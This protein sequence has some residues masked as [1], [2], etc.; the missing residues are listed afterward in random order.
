MTT[1]LQSQHERWKEARA[2]L[3]APET[4]KTPPR[5]S[6]GGNI[7]VLVPPTVD[8]EK[9]VMDFIVAAVGNVAGLPVNEIISGPPLKEVTQ[10]RNL[11][12]ALCVKRAQFQIDSISRHFEVEPAC[13]QDSA[14]KLG[15]ILAKH[16]ISHKTPLELSLPTIWASW[17]ELVEVKKYPSIRGIQKAVCHV[18]QVTLTDL[19][20]A[21][22]PK[23]IVEPRQIGMALC[24]RLTLKSLPE[25]GRLFGGR[26]H[27][28]VLHAGRKYH[29]LLEKVGSTLPE[30]AGPHE[31]AQAVFNE[32]MENKP[33]GRVPVRWLPANSSR[34]RQ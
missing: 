6:A 11:A 7:V 32:I 22:R 2:R 21:R 17:L 25:V 5:I 20:S 9:E 28:T 12:M 4:L 31:W 14:L 8:P 33:K 10:A 23:E 19:C 30:D 1:E 26:D 34:A 29:D 27:T 18:W 13:V 16:S 3:Q 15:P 24:R